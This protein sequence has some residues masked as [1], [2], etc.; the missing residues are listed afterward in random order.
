MN[1]RHVYLVLGHHVQLVGEMSDSYF[2]RK[3]KENG[4]VCSQLQ[5]TTL[6]M[7]ANASLFY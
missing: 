7:K 5:K 3:K 6:V 2:D 1:R 4:E